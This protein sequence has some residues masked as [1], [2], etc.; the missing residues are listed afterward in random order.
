MQV[1]LMSLFFFF[2]CCCTLFYD[3]IKKT[4]FLFVSIDEADTPSDSPVNEFVSDAFQSQTLSTDL[5]EVQEG[6]KR[7]GGT[8]SSKKPN[9]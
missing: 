3:K 4:L 2:S 5:K 1:G 9:E 6:I 8:N 7:L